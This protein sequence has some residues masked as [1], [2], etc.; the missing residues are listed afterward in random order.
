MIALNIVYIYNKVRLNGRLLVLLTAFLAS[1]FIFQ[2]FCQTAIC[3][4][5]ANC[6]SENNISITNTIICNFSI[7]AFHTC[8]YTAYLQ[9][10]HTGVDMV[11]TRIGLINELLRQC[12]YNIFWVNLSFSVVRCNE[13]I[14][15]GNYGNYFHM[16]R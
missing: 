4:Y 6:V 1:F 16:G 14:E 11:I 3:R 5:L 12:K 8:M 9:V 10:K 2:F 13:F 15:H 7:C